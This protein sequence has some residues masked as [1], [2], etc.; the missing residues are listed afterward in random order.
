[1]EFFPPLYV[2]P[3]DCC[4]NE[5]QINFRTNSAS[6]TLAHYAIPTEQSAFKQCG[7]SFPL[8]VQMLMSFA[9]LAFD[10]SIAYTA[11]AANVENITVRW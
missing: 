4:I 8:G 5:C 9:N 10:E 2:F 6:Y 1:M 3:L 11:S 7:S